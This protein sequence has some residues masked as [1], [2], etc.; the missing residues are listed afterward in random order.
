MH[1]L[2]KNGT[3]LHNM[4]FYGLVYHG[5]YTASVAFGGQ[6]GIPAMRIDAVAQ[7]NKNQLFFRVN[8]DAGAGISGMS[9]CLQGTFIAARTDPVPVRFRLVEA[10]TAA[11]DI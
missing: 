10:K 11:G 9:V 2:Q 5:M 6:R 3:V 1:Y 7:E 8:P 4:S